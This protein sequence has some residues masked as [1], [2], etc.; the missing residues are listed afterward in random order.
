MSFLNNALSMNYEYAVFWFD[1]C[2]A[3]TEDFESN[4]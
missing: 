2:W 3:V 4:T 1:G